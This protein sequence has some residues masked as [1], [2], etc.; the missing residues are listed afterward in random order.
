MYYDKRCH[1]WSYVE[2]KTQPLPFYYN[3][4]KEIKFLSDKLI[5]SKKKIMPPVMAI[6]K[7][8]QTYTQ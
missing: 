8:K 5:N 1:T 3:I 6:Y 2:K 4:S 7:V